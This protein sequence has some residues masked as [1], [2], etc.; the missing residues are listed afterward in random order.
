V[1]QQEL[2]RQWVVWCKPK[3]VLCRLLVVLSV[4]LE[5]AFD[6]FELLH[7]FHGEEKMKTSEIV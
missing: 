6:H 2:C 7:L 4:L 3:E 5:A 1:V